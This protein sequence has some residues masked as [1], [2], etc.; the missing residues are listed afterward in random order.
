MKGQDMK[1]AKVIQFPVQQ[2]APPKTKQQSPN[3][4]KDSFP[5]FNEQQIK[6]LRRSVKDAAN[7]AKQ[8][9]QVTAI[10]EWMLID[11]L[12]STGL[13]EAEAA[14]IRCGDLQAAYGESSII[15]RNGKGSKSRIV[16]IPDSLKLHMKSF[17]HWK[18]DR[19]EPTGKDD[20]LFIGQ[21]GAWKPSAVQQAV[22]KWL[23]KLNL[24]E[25][26]KSAHALRHSYAV[27]L[28]RKERDLRAVQ[29]QLGHSS[30]QTT[31]IYADTLP[32]D[33]QH[34]LKGLWN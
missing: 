18:S 19:Q 8:Q 14:D 29:K 22:K 10:R 12:T 3:P 31:Q 33:I 26:G 23:R 32:E 28:Y 21:R 27:A 5:Y 6:L 2:P 13:R 30:I 9:E 7:L 15:V 20:H 17:I 11:L 25:T 16:Q 34:Q 1:A 4:G 24:Y